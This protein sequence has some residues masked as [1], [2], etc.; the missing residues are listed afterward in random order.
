LA[1]AGKNKALDRFESEK[2]FNQLSKVFEG[3]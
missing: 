1:R 2:Q 3:L